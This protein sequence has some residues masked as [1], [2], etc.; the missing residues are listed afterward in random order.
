M[1][2]ERSDYPLP[3]HYYK[4]FDTPQAMAPPDLQAIVEG[5]NTGF[6]TFGAKE[7]FFDNGE[8]IFPN[9]LEN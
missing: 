1:S 2:N 7:S 5:K 8:K 3:P 9:Y 4:E 6:F